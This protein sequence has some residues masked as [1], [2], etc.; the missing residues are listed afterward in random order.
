MERKITSFHLDEHNDWVAELDC[1]HGQHVRH[2]P[3]FTNR[4]W[5]VSEEGRASKLGAV[6]NCVRCDALEFPDDLVAYKKTP[7]FTEETIPKGFQKD[8]STKA[9]VWGLLHVLEGTLIYTV[10]EPAVRQYEVKQGE[11]AV[12]APCLLH[13]AVPKGKVKF[14]VE[15]HTKEP[16]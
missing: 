6:L 9:G 15:F 13:S 16:K 11:Q 14:Y 3:P 12:I 8:H 7:E 10:N 2:K 4:P 1:F 5:V